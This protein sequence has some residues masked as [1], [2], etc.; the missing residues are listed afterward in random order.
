M[1][2]ARVTILGI[3]GLEGRL[4]SFDIS[5]AVGAAIAEE[6]AAIAN[7][8]RQN[9]PQDTGELIDSISSDADGLSGVARV[10]APYA[11]Y[12]E[13]GTMNDP[14]QPFAMPAAE[15]ARYRFPNRVADFIAVRIGSRP[16]I[17]RR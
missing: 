2:N 6:V 5:E 9:A 1:A 12:V 14:A 10:E 3:R 13:F 15:R 8:M 11:G 7:D 4:Q 16:T 17:F